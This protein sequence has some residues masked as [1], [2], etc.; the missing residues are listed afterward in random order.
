VRAGAGDASARGRAPDLIYLAAVALVFFLAGHG[1]LRKVTWY[2]AIDQYGYLTF[3]GDLAQGR[4]FHQ[5]PPIE[6]LAA[7]IPVPSVDVLAQTYVF[8]GDRMYCRYTP[9][10]P[11]ILAAWI[12][13][14]GPSAAHYLDPILFLGLLAVQLQLTRRVFATEPG[15]RWLALAGT[16]LLLL[17]PSY[18]H[19]WAITIL[20][21]ISAQLFALMAILV[22]VPRPQ[23]ISP[24]R[25]AAIGFLF[26]YLISVRVDALLFGLP[27]GALFLWQLLAQ[28]VEGRR[29]LGTRLAGIAPAVLSAAALFAVG[30]SPLLAYNYAA[31]GNP[32][33]PT[34]AMELER[35]FDA[36][37]PHPRG[38]VAV[39]AP[40]RAAPAPAGVAARG[41]DTPA[42]LDDTPEIGAPPP[43]PASAARKPVRPPRQPSWPPAVQG[44]GLQLRHLPATLPGNVRYIRNAFGDVILLLA[45][46]GIVTAI[47]RNRLLLV[48]TVPYC[49]AALIFYSCWGR[50][51]PRYLAG[52]FVL[53][54]LLALGGLTGLA[55]FGGR[56]RH[57]TG[58]TMGPVVALA[59]ALALAV[60]W[61][62]DLSGAWLV[63]RAAWSMGAWHGGS[64]LP[65]V[66]GIVAVLGVVAIL[67]GTMA[68]ASRAA[69]PLRG[70]LAVALAM[71]LITAAVARSMPG[72]H[73][74]ASFQAAEVEQARRTIESII[75]P[76]AIVITTTDVGRPAENIDYY[77]H[78]Y[79]L[80]LEDL[81]RWQWNIARA[82]GKFLADGR[83]L[84]LLLPAPSAR[85]RIALEQLEWFELEHIRHVDAQD[86]PQYFVASRF[87]TVPLDIYRV[88]LPTAVREALGSN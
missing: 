80:Y 64:A 8:T 40:H 55:S 34:Q 60:W 82:C 75:E 86:T 2:L 68:G 51:D 83:E 69:T 3:S 37:R 35:F 4:V 23:P 39:A 32:F 31:T 56:L 47:L 10:F 46:L 1:L 42:R 71:L 63:I 74:R 12:R 58:P 25:A 18:L 66:S 65:V 52:L 79:A 54:P 70:G 30:V 48:V 49:L 67:V 44:G 9:G 7:Q 33:R 29:P 11:I 5:W 19:L 76:G 41:V 27:I 57:S 72:W 77:T 20:R 15:A 73:R 62:R 45:G 85:G 38:G 22:A 21:D 24:R 81:E 6:H 84:Y 13:L 87:G 61:L 59:V 17:L 88:R 16:L 14:F 26:G 53:T 36:R 43:A 78:A 28:A 50:P